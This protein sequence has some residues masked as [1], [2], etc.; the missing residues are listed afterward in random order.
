MGR[1]GGVWRLEDV[2][3]SALRDVLL[4]VLAGKGRSHNTHVITGPKCCY[5]L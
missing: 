5:C 2:V 3:V 4:H 1:T